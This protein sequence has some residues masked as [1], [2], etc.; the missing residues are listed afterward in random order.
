MSAAQGSEPS[1]PSGP[2]GPTGPSQPAARADRAARWREQL[3]S[4]EA[5]AVSGLL[6]SGLYVASVTVIRRALPPPGATSAEA[7][8]VIADP[9]TH[10]AMRFGYALVPFAAVSFFWFMAVLRRRMPVEDQFASTVFVAGGTSFAVLYLVAASLVAA[11]FASTASGAGLPAVETL[12]SLRSIAN[13]LVFV[14]AIRLQTLVILSSNSVARKYGLF[15]RWLLWAGTAIAVVQV[16]NVALF[17]PLAL[18]FP[19]WVGLISA[20]L[21]VRRRRARPSGERAA[22]DHRPS[23]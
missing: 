18:T 17:E 15:P 8:A 13:G 4:I 10:E 5:A 9:Q 20:T 12:A 3:V 21:L 2:S 6:F 19:I 23:R 11:P 14:L 7:A 22:A 16:V 1:G